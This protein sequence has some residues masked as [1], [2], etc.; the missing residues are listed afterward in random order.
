MRLIA[1]AAA[2]AAAALLAACGGGTGASSTGSTGAAP[3]PTIAAKQLGAAGS[4][5]VDASGRAHYTNDQD[6]GGAVVCSGGCLSFWSPVTTR[7]TPTAGSLPGAVGVV[8][9]TNGT[10]QVTYDG[11]PLYSFTLDAPGKVTG[12]GARDAFGGQRFTWH[13]ARGTGAAP[14]GSGGAASVPATTPSYGY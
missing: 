10:R 8:A 14:T 12:D 7:T 3:A 5:L 13:V 1:P 6:H 2:L 4:V 9:R 11:K